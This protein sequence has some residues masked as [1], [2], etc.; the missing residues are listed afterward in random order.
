MFCDKQSYIVLDV[1]TGGLSPK[2]HSI[3]EISG[4]LWKPGQEIRPVFDCY[5]KEEEIV[6]IPRAM[7]INQIDLGKVKKQGRTPKE[8]VRYIRDRLDEVLGENRRPVKILAHN[9]SF[10]YGFLQ[11]LYNLAGEE[12]NKDFY[13]RTIDSASILE[14]LMIVNHIKGDRASADV[15]FES[16]NNQIKS[17]ERHRS[18][19]DALAT[20]KSMESLFNVYISGE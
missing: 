7:E 10:D 15:L 18:Y 19:Y 9:A 6:T 11:R 13:G 5:V 4:I 3:L 1:E 16:T 8:T 20:A 17:E 14:F 2:D 12:I